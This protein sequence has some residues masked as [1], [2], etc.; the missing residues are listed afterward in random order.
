MGRSR[1]SIP[2]TITVSAR[3]SDDSRQGTRS[4]RCPRLDLWLLATC[5]HLITG[6]PFGVPGEPEHLQRRRE[7]A[8]DHVERHNRRPVRSCRVT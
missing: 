4:V 7:V 3:F 8:Q 1:L 6:P 2:E 5:P